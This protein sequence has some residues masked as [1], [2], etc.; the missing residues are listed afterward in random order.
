MANE[1]ITRI[2]AEDCRIHLWI[3]S[4]LSVIRCV[5]RLAGCNRKISPSNSQ[6]AYRINKF[7]D[8]HGTSIIFIIFMISNA[9]HSA[10]TGSS[11]K[12]SYSRLTQ[13]MRMRAVLCSDRKL[14]RLF[15]HGIHYHFKGSE[16]ISN[17]FRS[18]ITHKHE[19]QLF[20][21]PIIRKEFYL[22]WVVATYELYTLRFH[23]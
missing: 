15:W 8:S 14:I 2:L 22:R 9:A 7:Q 17:D 5:V 11:V 1:F 4:C 20:F 16:T 19:N 6:F 10:E 12:S 13:K 3:L 18:N 21:T 23:E